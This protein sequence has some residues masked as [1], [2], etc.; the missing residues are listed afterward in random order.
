[1]KKYKKKLTEDMKI[2]M[3][4]F[5]LVEPPEED[6]GFKGS[7]NDVTLTFKSDV[8]MDNRNFRDFISELEKF[9]QGW[10][11]PDGYVERLK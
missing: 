2:K 11:V 3:L 5:S 7:S 10:V 6:I 1:M 8:V 9:L 4:K